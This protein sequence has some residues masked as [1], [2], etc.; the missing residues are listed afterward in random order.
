VFFFT[1]CYFPFRES[2]RSAFLIRRSP[3]LRIWTRLLCYNSRMPCTKFRNSKFALSLPMRQVTILLFSLRLW[4]LRTL[5]GIFFYLPKRRSP[6][7]INCHT[8]V[9]Q[10]LFG[11]FVILPSPP[12]LPWGYFPS[13]LFLLQGFYGPKFKIFVILSFH[14]F[15]PPLLCSFFRVSPQPFE[16]ESLLRSSFQE[17]NR[18]RRLLLTPVFFPFLITTRIKSPLR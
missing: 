6:T 8:V 17:G 10:S 3:S 15:T 14:R 9:S 11:L 13:R 1:F 12:F 2:S 7:S 18:S 4:E 16:G 5:V